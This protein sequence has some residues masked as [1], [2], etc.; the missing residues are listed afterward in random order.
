MTLLFAVF[1]VLAFA[2]SV[3]LVAGC[4]AAAQ[5]TMVSSSINAALDVFRSQ[6]AYRKQKDSQ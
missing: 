6:D 1:V 3:A 4:A 5:Y 2:F